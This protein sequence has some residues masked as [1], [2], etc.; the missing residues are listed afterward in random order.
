MQSALH[1]VQLCVILL[2]NFFL[3]KEVEDEEILTFL[4]PSPIGM[5]KVLY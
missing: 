1:D 3:Q 5:S 4:Q 2:Y